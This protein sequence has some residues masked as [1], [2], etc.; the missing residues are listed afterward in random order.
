MELQTKSTDDATT[1]TTTGRN[2]NTL[3]HTHI[4]IYTCTHSCIKNLT[5]LNNAKTQYKVSYLTVRGCSGG[6]KVCIKIPKNETI[7]F[8]MPKQHSLNNQTT[9]TIKF[10]SILLQCL[11]LRLHTHTHIHMH[12]YKR[13][14]RKIVNL[15]NCTNTRKSIFITSI[16]SICVYFRLRR[17][18]AF[19]LG[20]AAGCG[21]SSE[22]LLRASLIIRKTN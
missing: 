21:K 4:C 3:R 18:F 8:E 15:I 10:T 9:T 16:W 6:K 5:L 13:N 7:Q 20:E 19:D 14:I 17:W 22:S 1:T 2:A 11:H 12:T